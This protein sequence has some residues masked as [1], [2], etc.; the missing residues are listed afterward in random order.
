MYG[1][2]FLIC[3]QKSVEQKLQ[4]LLAFPIAICIWCIT[5]Y[6]VLLLDIPYNAYVMC[7]ILLCL[8]VVLLIKCRNKIQGDLVRNIIV[9][10]IYVVGFVCLATSGLLYIQLT[11]DSY[12]FISQYAEIITNMQSLNPDY[13]SML[14]SWTGISPALINSLPIMMGFETMYGIHHIIMLSL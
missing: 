1:K 6:V 3:T 4:N 7:F 11:E 5:S 10:C 13:C 9:S 14:M 2:L 8:L 12:Y